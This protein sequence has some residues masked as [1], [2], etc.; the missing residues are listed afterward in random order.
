[1]K[2][3]EGAALEIANW[4]SRRS[5]IELVLHPA[6]AS[7]S[8]HEIWKRDFTGSAGVFSIVFCQKFTKQQQV[9]AFVDALELFKVG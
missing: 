1:L 9:L 5:E 6:F 2:H 7:C 4:L 3:I 8:G